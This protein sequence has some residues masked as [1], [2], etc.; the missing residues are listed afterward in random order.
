MRSVKRSL[1][2]LCLLLTWWIISITRAPCEE[3]SPPEY[4]DS[5]I[6]FTESEW[7]DFG[8]E[9]KIILEETVEEAVKGAV[10]PLQEKIY[11]QQQVLKWAPA[12]AVV[13]AIV[14]FLAGVA[15]P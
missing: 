8:E 3:K 5:L 1:I 13:I 10:L 4:P 11:R 6:C 14:S 12:V 7:K 15:V 2:V 9:S